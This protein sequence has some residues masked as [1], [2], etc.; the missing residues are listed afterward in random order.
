MRGSYVEGTIGILL[1]ADDTGKCLV[2]FDQII[3][4]LAKILL[5]TTLGLVVDGKG[6]SSARRL[7]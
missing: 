6:S 7:N 2:R 1:R 5:A 4:G 3:R